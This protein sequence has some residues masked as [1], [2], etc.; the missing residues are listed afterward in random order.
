[1]I[2][3]STTALAQHVFDRHNHHE[4]VAHQLSYL[5]GEP[6]LAVRCAAH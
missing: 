3:Q 1:V 2:Q 6:S 5:C 4:A